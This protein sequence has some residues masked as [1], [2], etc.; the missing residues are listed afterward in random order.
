MTALAA[1]CH[2]GHLDVVKW[3]IAKG[4]DINKGNMDGV[5]PVATAA[6]RGHLEV[7]KALTEANADVLTGNADGDSVVA[8]ACWEDHAD[9]VRYLGSRRNHPS[10]SSYGGGG[11][12]GA[13]QQIRLDSRNL[14]G[15]TPLEVACMRGNLRSVQVLHELG[16]NMDEVGP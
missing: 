9:I 13:S 8:I 14:D 6:A 16:V 2:A 12:S 1:A 11:S 3:C 7:V 4:A 10:S 15:I 5:T